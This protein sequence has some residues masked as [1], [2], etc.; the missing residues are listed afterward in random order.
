MPDTFHS[1]NSYLR[2]D[3]AGVAPKSPPLAGLDAA[4]DP[5][6]PPVEGAGAK[7]LYDD[8]K[9]GTVSG[10]LSNKYLHL[11]KTTLKTYLSRQT[12]PLKSMGQVQLL[13]VLAEVV[14]LQYVLP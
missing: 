10:C 5:N 8:M 6:N 11:I 9:K 12:A 3:A 7:R 2:A 13:L 14:L 1:T 4:V